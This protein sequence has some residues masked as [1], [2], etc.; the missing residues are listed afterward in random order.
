[1]TKQENNILW[2]Y[3]E[4]YKFIDLFGKSELYLC[5]LD[6]LPDNREGRRSLPTLGLDNELLE[7]LNLKGMVPIVNE[8]NDI[9]RKYNFVSCWHRNQFQSK[10]MWDKYPDAIIA[11][12]TSVGAIKDSIQF[13]TTSESLRNAIPPQRQAEEIFDE[14]IFGDVKYID[15]ETE[16]SNPTVSI[17][18]FHKDRTFDFENEFR[19]CV[20]AWHVEQENNERPKPLDNVYVKVSLAILVKNIFIR[21]SF[22]DKERR[23][24]DHMVEMAGLPIRAISADY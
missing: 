4:L 6:K 21:S 11:I 17:S 16:Y 5:R 22:F 10:E 18:C 9:N 1:M 8:I 14:I 24:V 15:S 19:I 7:S 20:R 3:M 12:K 13:E 2:R 23:L